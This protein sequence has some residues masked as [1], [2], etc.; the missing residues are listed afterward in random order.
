MK[1]KL[2]AFLQRLQIDEHG[3]L[4][5]V[6]VF[7]RVRRVLFAVLVL[8]INA[9]LIVR[10]TV[11]CDIAL[12][13]TVLLSDLG[14]RN[15][16]AASLSLPLPQD[17]SSYSTRSRGAQGAFVHHLYPSGSADEMGHL[18]VNNVT[19]V[20][21]AGML[22]FT[23]RQNL[24]HYPETNEK[25]NPTLSYLVRVIDENGKEHYSNTAIAHTVTEVHRGYAYTRVAFD[26]LEITLGTD[27]VTL[28]VFLTDTSDTLLAVTLA[29]TDSTTSRGSLSA[30]T[31]RAV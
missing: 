31:Y 27:Y 30:Q 5:E 7:T 13:D 18:Q 20:E 29:G 11:S 17:F 24:R 8:L 25:G 1:M 16:A 6:S 21:G 22:Q 15:L 9:F 10:A 3:D 26:E 2:P 4:V 23:M 19:Y 12:S 14:A 28:Y